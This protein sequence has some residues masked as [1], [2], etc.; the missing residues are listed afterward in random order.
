MFRTQDRSQVG[1]VWVSIASSVGIAVL[2]VTFTQAQTQNPTPSTAQQTVASADV[3]E[4]ELETF[5]KG[6]EDALEIQRKLKEK[7]ASVQDGEEA[8]RL[9]QEANTEM[10]EAIKEHGIDVERYNAIARSIAQDPELAQRVQAKRKE[11]QQ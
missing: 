1:S 4:A 7:L 6:L 9:Q 8:K 3:P 2:M 10:F 5:T 11:L